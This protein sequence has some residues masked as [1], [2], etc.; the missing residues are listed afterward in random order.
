MTKS[1]E[2]HL[3]SAYSLLH[4]ELSDIFYNEDPDGM[5]VT[6]GAP[7]DEYSPEV[8]RLIPRLQGVR[9]RKAV[10]GVVR[11]MFP[12]AGESLINRVFD[13]WARFLR[14]IE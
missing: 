10:A 13:A 1:R 8:S 14:E 5:G 4:A 3:S 6:A 12:T 7:D 2:E 11:Q 9:D